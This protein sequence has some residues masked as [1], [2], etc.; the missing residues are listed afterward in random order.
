MN[1]Y[2]CDGGLGDPR[3]DPRD[4]KIAPCS[5]CEQIIYETA[6]EG[7]EDE[8]EYAYLESSLDEF[9]VEVEQDEWT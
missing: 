2:I 5:R 3:I 6:H 8:G 1:C 7:D 9:E 4:D